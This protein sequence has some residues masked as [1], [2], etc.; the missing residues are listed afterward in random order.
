MGKDI[1]ITITESEAWVLFELVNRFSE[2]DKLSIQDQSEEQALWNLC[3]VFEKTMSYDKELPYKE[4]I[5]E[6]RNNL[7]DKESA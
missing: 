6:C 4:F 3:C 7:R 1:K 5:K 2:T